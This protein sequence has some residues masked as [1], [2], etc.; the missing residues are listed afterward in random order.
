MNLSW[1][2]RL[3]DW[4]PQLFRE[5]KGRLKPR[6]L[7]IAV[8]ISLLGQLLLLIS[9]A[10]QLPVDDAR[11][12]VSNRYCISNL[13]RECI[14]DAVGNFT[15]NWQL[16]SL[17]VFTWLSLIGIFAMLVVGTY[18]LISDLSREEHRGTLNFIRLSPQPTQSILTGKLLGVPILLYQDLRKHTI[19][20]V[21]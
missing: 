8:A 16:W 21:R 17:D 19:Y 11:G 15:I 12:V 7:T 1:L 3:G 4:N 13:N 6:N 14:R 5:L 20:S 10:G 9:F 18:M 2:A